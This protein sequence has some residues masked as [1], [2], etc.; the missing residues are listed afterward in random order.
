MLPDSSFQVSF[1]TATGLLWGGWWRIGVELKKEQIG[2]ELA[3]VTQDWTGFQCMDI[4]SLG[5]TRVEAQLGMGGQTLA[6][7]LLG[8][9]G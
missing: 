3:W 1:P 8:G 4:G 5:F 9:F 7:V 6:V 2:L